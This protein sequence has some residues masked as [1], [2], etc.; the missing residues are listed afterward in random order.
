MNHPQNEEKISGSAT[1]S[2]YNDPGP[3][4]FTLNKNEA[5]TLQYLSFAIVWNNALHTALHLKDIC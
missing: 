2:P 4:F 3:V 1:I 5:N